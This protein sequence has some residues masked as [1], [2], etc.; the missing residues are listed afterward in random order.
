MEMKGVVMLFAVCYSLNC[1]LVVPDGRRSE[2]SYVSIPKWLTFIL[3]FP[4][5]FT[6]LR[7]YDL[8]TIVFQAANCLAFSLMTFFAIFGK[9]RQ[10]A[11]IGI[12][13]LLSG[14]VVGIIVAVIRN[15]RE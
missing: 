1:F 3:F 2:K 15:I 12:I 5:G 14:L 6:N 9:H 4:L 13:A 11:K 8:A 7:S 10:S